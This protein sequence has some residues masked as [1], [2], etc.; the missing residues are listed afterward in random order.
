MTGEDPPRKPERK[1]QGSPARPVLRDLDPRADGALGARHGRAHGARAHARAGAAGGAR[2]AILE[3]GDRALAQDPRRGSGARPRQDPN[4]IRVDVARQAVGSVVDTAALLVFQVSPLWLL[5]V[6]YDVAKGSRR[7]LD[8]VVVELRARGALDPNVKIDGVDQ[9]LTILER[10]A[11][12]LQSDVDRP[13]LSVEDLR[14]SVAEIRRAI[15]T[16]PTGE[17]AADAG[18]VAL[19][20]EETSAREG[21]R[22]ARC[23]TRSPS[24]RLRRHASPDAPPPPASTWRNATSSSAGGAPTWSNARGPETWLLSILGKCRGARSG[25]ARGELRSPDRH[26]H[27]AARLGEALARRARPAP[28]ARRARGARRGSQGQE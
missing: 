8:E 20:L 13:P 16:A 11:G 25:R 14:S 10:T 19:E 26:A 9:L 5:A 3:R 15:E 21:A 6:V 1:R 17:I 18:K 12:E 28:G 27:G 24:A 22:C 2:D 7:Y 23:R 4:E